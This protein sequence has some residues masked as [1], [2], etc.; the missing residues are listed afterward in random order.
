MRV[1]PPPRFARANPVLSPNV[2]AGLYVPKMWWNAPSPSCVG[3]CRHRPYPITDRYRLF[4]SLGSNPRLLT[5][6]WNQS[7]PPEGGLGFGAWLKMRLNEVPP[8]V[9]SY[10]PSVGAPCFFRDTASTE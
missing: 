4:A 6:P 1:P 3:D 7:D 2:S 8:F 5:P 9:D 10:S